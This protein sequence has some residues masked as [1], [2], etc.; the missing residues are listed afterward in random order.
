MHKWEAGDGSLIH[1]EI[2]GV[3]DTPKPVLLLLPG[4]LGAIAN[5]WRG[6]IRPLAE[7]FQLILVDFR[8]HGRSTNNAVELSLSLLLQDVVGLLDHLQ[9]GRI[10]VAGYSLG[11]Y[12]GL[13][14]AR[15]DPGRVAALTAHGVKFYWN[16]DSVQK[17]QAQ[18]DPTTIA[19]RVPGYAD[20]LVKDH[21]ARDWR[22]LVRQSGILVQEMFA[23][24]LKEKHLDGVRSPALVSVGARD[25]L[26]TLP[27]AQRLSTMLPQGQLLVLPGV[28]HPFHTIPYMPLIPMM[29]HFHQEAD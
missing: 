19:Q 8:G 26:V 3:T 10:H 20:Q 13:L 27:E 4:L 23:N 18:L 2:Y 9:V 11:G 29:L 24:G 5:Q 21:G 1:Y 15:N 14:L 25:E 6:F 16:R 22:G 28:H 17:M 12:C 7:Q